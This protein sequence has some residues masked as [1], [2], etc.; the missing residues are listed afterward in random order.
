MGRPSFPR[1]TL[2]IVFFLSGVAGLGYQVIWGR[3]LHTVFGASSW[4]LAAILSAFM[5][6]LALGSLVA[7]RRAERMTQNPLAVY[8]VLEIGIGLYAAAFPLL[9]DAAVAVQGQFFF[10]WVENHTLYGL[11][12]FGLCFAVLLVPTSLMGATLPL[13]SAYVAGRTEAPTRWAGLLYGI[14][15]TGAVFGTLLSGFVL[16]PRLGLSSSN[17]LFVAV[18]LLV[19]VVALLRT[20]SSTEESIGQGKAPRDQASSKKAT[21]KEARKGNRRKKKTS[22]PEP[23]PITSTPGLYGFVLGLFFAN[24]VFNLAYEVLWGRALALIIGT[25][26]Y[27]FSVMLGVFLTGIALG[28]LWM[29]RRLERVR[30]PLGLLLALQ[31]VMVLWV[32]ASPLLVNALP[33]IF[34]RGLL[35]LGMDWA[36]S[37][38]LKSILC[39]FLLLPLTL[40]MG[41]V[42]P[43]G[44][45]LAFDRE[46]GLAREVGDLYGIN[47]V[48]GILGAFLGGFLI[49]PL[50]GV[51][52][53]IKGIALAHLLVIA[54]LVARSPAALEIVTRHRLP[55]ATVVAT[56]TLLAL[57]AQWNPLILA[58]GV[59]FQPQTFFDGSGQVRLEER[60]SQ[61]TLPYHAEGT[62]ATVDVLEAPSGFRALAINGKSVATSNYYDYRVQRLLGI[63]P[64]L[65]HP[66][67]ERILVI[68]LGT[69]M[70]SGTGSIDPQTKSLEIVEITEEVVGATEYFL[71]WNLGVVHKPITR[72][73]VEDATHYLRFVDRTYQVITSDPIH[74]FVTGAGNL[75]SVEG[76][77]AAQAKLESGGIYCQWVPLYQLDD[78]DI[79]SILRTFDEVW[80][81]AT[82]WVTGKDFILCGARDEFAIDFE[83]FRT[84]ASQ[85]AYLEIL[86]LLGFWT[87]EEVLSA[88]IGPLSA[89]REGH[90]A[91]AVVNTV[92][93]PYL[94]FSA[95]RAIFLATDA[96]NLARVLETSPHLP[97][98][99]LSD[100]PPELLRQRDEQRPCTELIWAGF[101]A[102]RGGDL[103]TATRLAR[104]AYDLCPNL[105]Y[106]RHF[107]AHTIQAYSESIRQTEPERALGLFRRALDLDP[108]TPEIGEAVRAL[109]GQIQGP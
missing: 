47:T 45:H 104:R 70:T 103:A 2:T 49:I 57:V 3:M 38:A 86:R 82:V 78:P 67:P 97:P 58:S 56:A 98:T 23:S 69:G 50:F 105:G 91:G 101:V 76:Y 52:Q 33:E 81:N 63:L 12:R 27:A 34:L 30:N 25:T 43:L 93:R 53:G 84:K 107:A 66:H 40:G 20:R 100:P 73:I 37:V 92:D 32:L 85:P 79:H 64:L 106:V 65:L 21:K 19:G 9:L 10:R 62:S 41:A 54:L 80:A 72:V 108:H 55:W 26:T 44:I 35:A 13:L 99:F 60:M 48:G 83:T 68:G 1:L 46:Q 28:S 36:A 88:Y 5:A 7:G 31:G 11:I 51:E 24:G 61:A 6:G 74:P 29:T 14:N 8:G 95:P 17:L 102:E 94:E 16:I 42:F 4:A 59:Y 109:E 87:P 89:L 15:T 75:Y 77:E 96:R 39:A 18:N 90:F 22:A 71:E